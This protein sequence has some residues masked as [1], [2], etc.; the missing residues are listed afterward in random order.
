ML[1]RKCSG[2]EYNFTT[3][4]LSSMGD[5][6]ISTDLLGKIIYMNITA[7]EIT[8]WKANDAYKQDFDRVFPIFEVDTREELEGPIF[9]ALKA[10]MTIGLKNKSIII[11][12]SGEQKFISASCSPIRDSDGVAT[13]VVVVFRDITRLK[14]LEMESLNEGNNLKAIFNNAPVGMVILDEIAVISQVNDAALILTNKKREQVIGSH[15]GD[16]FNCAESTEDEGGCGYGSKCSDCEI[17]K[18]IVLAFDHS[19]STSNIEFN[20]IFTKDGKKREFWFRASVTPIITNGRRNSIV[21]LMDITERK[22]QELTVLKSRDYCNNLL[23]QIPSL[24][25]KTDKGVECNY[26]SRSWKDFTGSAL[27]ELSGYGWTNVIHPKDLDR[28]VEVSTEA[29]SKEDSFQLEIRFRRYDGEYRWCLVAGAPYY[30]LE[31]KFDGYIGSIYD[32]TKSKEAKE[33]LQRYQLLSENARDIILFIDMDGRIVEA[34]KAAV[35]AYGYSYEELLTLKIFD[36]R[37]GIEYTK[38][39]TKQVVEKGIFF[40]TVHRRKDG[41]CFEVEV[42]TQS[43]TLNNGRVLLSIIRDISER[44]KSQKRILESQAKYRSLFM[45]MNNGYAYCKVIYNDE[46][47]PSDLKFIEVNEAFEK[48]SGMTKKYII[49]RRY[50]ELFPQDKAVLIEN[51]Q[52]YVNT[53]ER[54]KSVHINEIYLD[55]F[56]RWYSVSI[57][58]PEGKHIAMLITDITHIKQSEIQLVTAKE[59]AVAANK[60]KS[61]FLANMSHEIRTPINGIVGMVDL[62][63]LTNLDDEQKDN[64]ATAKSCANSLLEIINDILDF[65][66]MEAG[67]LS[68]ENVNFNIKELVE[69][70]IKMHSSRVEEKGLELNYSFSSTIPKFLV[71]DPNRLR[72]VLNNLISN[73]IKFT[74][75]GDITVTIKKTMNLDNE[76]E[77]KFIV[78]DTGIGIASEDLGRL[79]KSFSQIDESFTKRFEGT[80]LGLAIS[81]QLLEAM[82]GRIWVESKKGKGSTFHFIL[83]FKVGSQVVE[84]TEQLPQQVSKTTKSMNILL[85]EDDAINQKVIMKMLKKKGHRVETAN[86]GKEAVVL[87]QPGKYDV[88]LMDIQMPE[89]DGVEAT[90]RIKEREV[91]GKQIPIIAMTAYALQGD[92]E[93]FLTLGMD[94]YVSKPIQMRELFYILDNIVTVQGKWRDFMPDNVVLT[95]NGEVTFTSK[96]LPS[97]NKQII[98]ALSEIAEYIK[99]IDI[100]MESNNIMLI[101]N[102]AHNIKIISNEIDAIGIKD[103]AFKIELAARRGSLE[104]AVKYIERIKDEFKI[105]RE[106]IVW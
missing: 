12:K 53:L 61:E 106:S 87:F 69:E 84:K 85:V 14:T 91:M 92:R 77:L 101:E 46:E 98:S 99:K 9:R 71:G 76:V 32:I 60:S 15:F 16:S 74:N 31:G 17:R 30:D 7:E 47:V 75:C 83:K 45:N 40:E 48:M 103:G 13:G 36:I 54:G 90:R 39:Q 66:K 6:V 104:E 8:G 82:G 63:L 43:T 20:K 4:I 86:N 51:I 93:R 10:D 3:A 25:W 80:G 27:E 100:A 2:K 67:K 34:N 89:M 50:T 24:V 19:Q 58:S 44:K 21:T 23:N 52:K 1:N 57:Y 95:E 79:F 5:G 94:G 81:K 64:L 88:I 96:N 65:S 55:S 105:Y 49:S 38:G 68:I 72:Q 35:K 97:S 59:E 22:N 37:G 56:G 73:A 26:V 11:T 18:A 62:T 28:Y 42:S 70:I 78:S 102:I 41:S 33:N 29:M